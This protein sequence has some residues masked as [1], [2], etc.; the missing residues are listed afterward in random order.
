M[1]APKASTERRV[2]IL[3]TGGTIAGTA[4]SATDSVGYRAASLGVEALVAAVPPLAGWP[5]ECLQV[6]QLDSKDMTLATVAGAG[7]GGADSSCSAPRSAAWS[8]PTAPTRWRRRP[9]SCTACWRRPS[10]W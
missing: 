7:R 3:G 10:R 9:T 2:V 1:N 4:D 6:A 8:S 5:I